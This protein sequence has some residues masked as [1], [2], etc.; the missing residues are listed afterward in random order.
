VK[1]AKNETRIAN[2]N[3]SHRCKSIIGSVSSTY[4]IK[5]TA[6]VYPTKAVGIAMNSGLS[7]IAVLILREN[8]SM[9]TKIGVFA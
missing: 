8:D 5:K 7:L 1:L 6:K 2:G 9:L 4:R 3:A